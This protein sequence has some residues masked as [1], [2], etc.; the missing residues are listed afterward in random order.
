MLSTGLKNSILILLIILIFHVFLTNRLKE[1]FTQQPIKKEPIIDKISFADDPLSPIS[2]VN[3]GV[4]DM[5]AE[6][7]KT[8][9]LPVKEQPVTKNEIFKS[10]F[11]NDLV[12]DESQNGNLDKFFQAEMDIEKE[13]EEATKCPIPDSK[14]LPESST[15]DMSYEKIPA[16]L[17][18]NKEVKANCELPQVKKNMLII[19]EYEDENHMNGGK[20]F[21]NLSAYNE[22]DYPYEAL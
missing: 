12:G 8:I 15:C 11:G 9:E 1:H 14:G 10:W 5:E 18:G 4:C 22:E 2:T 13:L 16:N 7:V 3:D 6:T 19:N 20:L 17:L 21:M